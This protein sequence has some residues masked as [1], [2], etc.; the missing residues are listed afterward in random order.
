[1]A[2][3]PRTADPELLGVDE[4]E[5]SDRRRP[6]G[7]ALAVVAVAYLVAVAVFMT[8]D[9]QGSLG[10]ALELRAKKL[11]AMTLVGTGL[12]TAAVLFHTITGNRILTPALIGL[13]SLYILIQSVS[14]A[15]FGALTFVRFDE[16]IRF[17]VAVA[18][19]VAFVF[20]LNAVFLRRAASDLPLLVLG[21]IVLGGMFTS[22]AALVIRVLDPNEF[23]ILEDL[24]F[25]SFTLVNEELLLIS[26]ILIGLILLVV[27]RMR[28]TLDVVALGRPTAIALGADYDRANRRLILLIA[29][30]VAVPTA[31]VGPVTFLGL[32]ASNATYEMTRSFRHHITI[33]LSALTAATLLIVA[34]FVLE[35]LFDFATRP[36]IIVGFVGG[37]VFIVLVLREVK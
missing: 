32:L 36:S 4:P 24:L 6:L 33:P 15:F 20:A 11:L 31:L 5:A 18:V 21:G 34:Q 13:D 10:F 26:C 25:A 30:L 29:V 28:R 14:V 23:L 1:M 35:E 12:A 37:V 2:A 27:A 3:T 16:R 19:M 7:L 8:Y 17:A 22:M 9:I